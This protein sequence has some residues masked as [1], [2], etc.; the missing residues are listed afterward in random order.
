MLKTAVPKAATLKNAGKFV[1]HV[2]PGVVRPLHVLWNQIIGFF[3]LA[4]AGLTVPSAIREF[5]DPTGHPR[6]ILTL[7][8]I[9]IMAGFGISSFWKARKV[10]RG[11][12]TRR[13]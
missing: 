10:S 8:F 11:P 6:L 2:I 12:R 1:Q 7:P 4:L 3:F 9:V 5:R 13:T